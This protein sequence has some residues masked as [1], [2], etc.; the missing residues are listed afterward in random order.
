MNPESL[1]LISIYSLIFTIFNSIFS[2]PFFFF[3]KA[4]S[5]KKFL[6]PIFGLGAQ[7][8]ILYWILFLHL[9]IVKSFLVF[10]LLSLIVSAALVLQKSFSELSEICKQFF[11]TH[12]TQLIISLIFLIFFLSPQMTHLSFIPSYEVNHDPIVILNFAHLITHP[13]TTGN[14]LENFNLKNGYPLGFSLLLANYSTLFRL[15]AYIYA[16][17]LNVTIFSFTSLSLAAIMYRIFKSN[18]WTSTILSTTGILSYMSIQMVN[19]S[20]Y[21][22][23]LLTPF[24][25]AIIYYFLKGIF[26]KNYKSF[27]FIALL[28][29]FSFL[30]Y[31]ASIFLWIIPLGILQLF[32]LLKSK[33]NKEKVQYIFISL[34]IFLFLLLPYFEAFVNFSKTITAPKH[35][36][37][38]IQQMRGNTL[39]FSSIH[40]AFGTWGEKDFRIPETTSKRYLAASISTV[41][42]FIFLIVSFFLIK[43]EKKYEVLLI[44]FVFILP[45]V[46][47]RFF[48]DSPYVFNKTLYYFSCLIL[49]LFF[50]SIYKVTT[51]R[52]RPLALLSFIPLLTILNGSVSSL[53]Y[54]PTPPLSKF[55]EIKS[56][57]IFAQNSIVSDGREFILVDNEDWARYFLLP[58]N[59]CVTHTRTHPCKNPQIEGNLEEIH[60]I[61]EHIYGINKNFVNNEILE[62]SE[63]LWESNQYY[64]LRTL[65]IKE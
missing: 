3:L 42:I 52:F 57:S 8:S 33:I 34:L 21:Q 56:L 4:R 14:V 17:I 23:V 36:E 54:I 62:Q 27:L 18:Y 48:T 64:I 24:L 25:F 49:P 9:P 20:F 1:T 63:I 55:E 29:G 7:I 50:I 6:A 12:C 26:D 32:T 11:L 61:N 38:S 31:T 15:D 35:R 28:T 44:F 53:L 39:G 13:E 10:A 41:I 43:K 65:K 45:I 40:T 19:Q 37:H 60:K 16:S 5:E 22:Q 46:Y 51:S 58:L 47:F 30:S 59:S 2:F